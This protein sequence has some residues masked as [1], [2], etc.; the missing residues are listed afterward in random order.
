MIV[1]FSLRKIMVMGDVISYLDLVLFQTFE[2][3]FAVRVFEF[4]LLECLYVDRVYIL[5]F[6]LPN[7]GG[8]YR[9][10]VVQIME[11]VLQKNYNLIEVV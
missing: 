4:N 11:I 3:D 9:R 2:P 7:Y 10:D 5:V 8:G 1:Q 6:S